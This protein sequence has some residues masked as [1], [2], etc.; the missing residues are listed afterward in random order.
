MEAYVCWHHLVGSNGA[1]FC[2]ESV[3]RA[4]KWLSLNCYESIKDS[5]YFFLSIEIVENEFSAER[6]NGS[7]VSDSEY[8]YRNRAGALAIFSVVTGR[9]DVIVPANVM[10]EPRVFQF[11]LSPDQVWF[12]SLFL[13]QVCP[14]LPCDKNSTIRQTSDFSADSSLIEFSMSIISVDV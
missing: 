3:P 5:L 14:F 1:T 10:E 11:W 6:W 13:C 2:T 9:S 4:E 8:V 7:W 12:A